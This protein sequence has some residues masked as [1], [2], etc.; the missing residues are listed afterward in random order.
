MNG[1]SELGSN[2]AK[3]EVLLLRSDVDVPDHKRPQGGKRKLT[4]TMW[5]LATATLLPLWGSSPLNYYIIHYCRMKYPQLHHSLH[6]SPG[7]K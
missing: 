3:E 4:G 7:K 2:Q 6:N 1:E 5:H